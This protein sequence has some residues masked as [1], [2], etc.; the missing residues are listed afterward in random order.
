MQSL[1]A[2]QD[3]TGLVAQDLN[4]PSLPNGTSPA[5]VA[6]FVKPTQHLAGLTQDDGPPQ[7]R[8][9]LRQEDLQGHDACGRLRQ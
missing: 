3:Y 6:C 1:D 9:F 5:C 7:M 2:G 4:A 8:Q